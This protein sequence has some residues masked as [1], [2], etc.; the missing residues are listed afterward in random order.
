M[1]T[2]TSNYC[3]RRWIV[4]PAILEERH[5]RREAELRAA[6]QAERTA[7]QLEQERLERLREAIL[8]RRRR[9]LF[10]LQLTVLRCAEQRIPPRQRLQT[11][12]RT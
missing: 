2:S 12:R 11:L 4:P 6:L 1:V 8:R 3:P 5:L 7:R 9:D 10:R